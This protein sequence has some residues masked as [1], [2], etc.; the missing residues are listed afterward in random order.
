[1]GRWL[2][3]LA[4][5][6]VL[7]GVA[8]GGAYAYLQSAFVTPS[9]LAFDR[10]IIIP[11]GTGVDG[12]AKI[13]ADDG[14]IADPIIF[15]LG[16]RLEN[17]TGKETGFL[18]AGEFIIPAH[19]SAKKVADILRFGETV[20]RKITIAEGLT[21]QEILDQIRITDGLTGNV[22]IGIPEGSLLPETYHF[23]YGDG[24]A[25]LVQ[26]MNDDLQTVL[27]DLWQSRAQDLPFKTAREAVILA[28]II[29]KETGLARER[30]RVS[31][32][33]INR[34]NKGMRLQS[35]PTVVY[36]ITEGSGPLGR[37]LTRADLDRETPYNT[38]KIKGFPPTPIAN[39]GRDA[40]RAAL[41]P[42]DTDEL[43]FVADGQGGHNFAKTLKD[44]NRNVRAYRRAVE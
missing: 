22:P 21:T 11:K 38:Y 19:S 7:T 28:S 32:V 6:I 16:L 5:L 23:K 41:N 2:R 30:D 13:L 42:M 44:H 14:L 43:Y 24:R 39:P 18:K 27:R 17:L 8:L 26:R 12:I 9:A 29:E 20:V 3:R 1:M 10:T 40:I 37:S 33:F 36:G 15:R 35:D 34:L 31:G 25:A 4:F